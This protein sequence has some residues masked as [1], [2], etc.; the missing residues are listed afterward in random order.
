M[1]NI[2][3]HNKIKKQR[4]YQSKNSKQKSAHIEKIPFSYRHFNFDIYNIY[5]ISLLGIFQILKFVLHIK[6]V[7]S[8]E[9]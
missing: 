2:T 6:N 3:K 9:K 1:T 8:H 7:N 4:Q 5:K